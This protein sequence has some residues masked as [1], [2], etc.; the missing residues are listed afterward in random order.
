MSCHTANY[1]L[2]II[3]LVCSYQ[4]SNAFN[5]ASH[6]TNEGYLETSFIQELI[7]TFHPTIL[8]ETGTYN[9][10]NAVA[11]SPFFSEVHTV[12]LSK[13]LFNQAMQTVSGHNNIRLYYGSSPEIITQIGPSLKGRILFWLDAHYSGGNTALSNDNISDPEA[14]TAIRKEL[15]A[16]KNANIAECTILIDDIRGFG[17]VINETDYL[18]CWAYPPLQEVCAMG[19]EINPHFSFALVGDILI[20]YDAALCTPQFSPIVTACTQDRLYDGNNLSDEALLACEHTIMHAEGEEKLFIKHL[21]K[22]MTEYGDPLFHYDLWYALVAMGEKNWKEALIALDK[23]PLR[24]QGKTIR[25]YKHSRLEEYRKNIKESL[26][27][28]N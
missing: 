15:K 14:I 21:Y 20:M 11:A 25:E 6:K 28:K 16:I 2:A 5:F 3:T 13:T 24:I 9:G 10:K 18:G 23:V 17:S 1:F 8:V 19:K 26:G 4:P 22:Q 7:N 12:E 27:E